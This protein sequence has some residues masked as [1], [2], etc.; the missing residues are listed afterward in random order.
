LWFHYFYNYKGPSNCG[1]SCLIL[2]YLNDKFI[3]EYNPTIE[4]LYK[5]KKSFESNEYTIQIFDTSGNFEDDKDLRVETISKCDGFILVFDKSNINTFNELNNFINEIKEVKFKFFSI[6]FGNKLDL[7]DNSKIEEAEFKNHFKN[8]NLPYY[9][10]SVKNDNNSIFIDRFNVL[11][12]L[13]LM[14]DTK[15]LIN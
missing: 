15:Y 5:F 13:I 9:E 8:L 4:D 3:E 7:V 1:K 2:K 11:F 12:N 6:V 14:N 10:I